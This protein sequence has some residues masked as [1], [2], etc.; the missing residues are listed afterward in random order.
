MPTAPN[1]P[2]WPPVKGDVIEFLDIDP[3]ETQKTL[4]RIGRIIHK[5]SKEDYDLYIIGEDVFP[6]HRVVKLN[7]IRLPRKKMS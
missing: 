3:K 1:K 5:R 7:Q 6:S 2:S 4:W